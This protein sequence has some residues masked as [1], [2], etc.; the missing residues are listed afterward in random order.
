LRFRPPLLPAAQLLLDALQPLLHLP[1]PF[2][3]AAELFL[4]HALAVWQLA[5]RFLGLALDLGQ[6]L[7][8]CLLHSPLGFRQALLEGFLY[9]AL[10]FG[11]PAQG[12]VDLLAAL[13]LSAAQPLQH[14]PGVGDLAERSLDLRLLL[15][16][17]P[18]RLLDQLLLVRQF[19]EGPLDLPLHVRHLPDNRFDLRLQLWQVAQGLLNGAPRVLYCLPDFTP[20]FRREPAVRDS[21]DGTLAARLGRGDLSLYGDLMGVADPVE[22][23]LLRCGQAAVAGA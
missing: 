14:P 19:A 22:Y 2:G 18:Q 7:A 4:H 23:L 20:L 3:E 9:P 12:F 1:H 10:H 15:W 5:E 8:K 21:A 17:V 6:A 16:Q 11:E 13:R